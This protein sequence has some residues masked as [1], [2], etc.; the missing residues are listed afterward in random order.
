MYKCICAEAFSQEE[1][2]SP[3]SLTSGEEADTYDKCFPNANQS[4]ALLHKH[5]GMRT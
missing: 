3:E 1:Q 4:L 5:R 2:S